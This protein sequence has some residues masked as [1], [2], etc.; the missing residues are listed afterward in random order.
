MQTCHQKRDKLVS[1][2]FGKGIKVISGPISKDIIEN[3]FKSDHTLG[4]G[5]LGFLEINNLYKSISN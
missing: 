1:E 5:H 2:A 4:F 3:V